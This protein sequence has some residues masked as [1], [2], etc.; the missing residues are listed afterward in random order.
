MTEVDPFVIGMIINLSLLVDIKKTIN[1]LTD[2]H[3]IDRQCRWDEDKVQL[4][5]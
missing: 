5:K 2:G 1:K 3:Y 4:S